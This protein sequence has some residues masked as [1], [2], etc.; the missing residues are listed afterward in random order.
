MPPL[1]AIFDWDGVIV[2]PSRVQGRAGVRLPGETGRRMPAEQ[3]QAGRG[4]K[5]GVILP[6]IRGW[7]NSRLR[8]RGS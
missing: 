6:D 7:T 2:E 4:R 5:R 1:A 3:C 8:S